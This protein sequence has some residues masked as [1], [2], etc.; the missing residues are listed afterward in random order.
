MK[1]TPTPFTVSYLGNRGGKNFAQ[2]V[3]LIKECIKAGKQE[4][5]IIDW[6][7]E[8]LLDLKSSHDELLEAAAAAS[9]SLLAAKAN[10]EIGTNYDDVIELLQKAIQKAEG[11]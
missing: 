4:I 11:K 2:A 10:G 7:N 1:R 9:G 5:Q 3:E 8:K 6:T